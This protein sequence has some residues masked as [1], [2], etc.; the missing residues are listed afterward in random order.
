MTTG[1]PNVNNIF[2]IY[3]VITLLF[4]LWI[5]LYDVRHHKIRNTALFAFFIWCLFSVPITICTQLF[6]TWQYL[7]LHCLFGFIT[8]FGIFLFVSMSTNGSIGGGDIKLV[9]LLGILYG[10][11]GLM[12]VLITACLIA[13]LHHLFYRLLKRRKTESIPFAPYLFWGCSIYILPRL[14]TLL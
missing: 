8:G 6:I 2:N 5:A 10:T 14:F 3:H 9:G 13:L 11:S 1:T 7:L 12:A 4:L